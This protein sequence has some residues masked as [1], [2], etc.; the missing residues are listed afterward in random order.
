[1]KTP[2]I[3]L[4]LLLT[5][6]WS[7]SQDE[8]TNREENSHG[9]TKKEL[10]SDPLETHKSYMNWDEEKE[11]QLQQLTSYIG[12]LMK[13]P[14]IR[15]EVHN[16]AETD[17]G[18]VFVCLWTV[19]DE[20]ELNRSTNSLLAEAFFDEKNNKYFDV[21]ALTR[22]VID[23]RIGITA[24]YLAENFD[25]SMNNITMTYYYPGMYADK[26][27]D[28][29]FMG[30]TPGMFIDNLNEYHPA[31]TSQVYQL[32]VND[33][34]AS[35][36]PTMVVNVPFS[37]TDPCSMAEEDYTPPSPPI[38]PKPLCSDL[39]GSTGEILEVQMPEFALQGNIRRWPNPNLI[40]CWVATGEFEIGSDGLPKLNANVNYVMHEFEVSRKRGRKKTWMYSN[41]SFII[42]NW[43][44]ESED[45]YIVWG[46]RDSRYNV[47]HEVSV[48]AK[49]N[50][51]TNPELKYT[52][53]MVTK[54][55]TILVS[56]MGVNKCALL[57][58]IHYELDKGFG[59]RGDWP[60]YGFGKVRTFFKL[61]FYD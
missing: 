2:R 9:L 44:Y 31:E 8:I 47:N 50:D 49:V 60:I 35:T 24:P 20:Y 61:S 5:F 43:K 42:H 27:D 40:S 7:C 6:I 17:F 30:E 16:S 23:N 33:D 54:P 52:A 53:K 51:P 25:P 15:Q 26:N 29:E 14:E 37:D 19:L 32:T 58:D 10:K 28:P 38:N 36:H 3:F 57:M 4:F 22:F 34:Y 48:S 45:M 13:I 59:I 1:M 55:N 18:A 41:I 46:S 39:D 21:E 56:G 11:I 12:Y